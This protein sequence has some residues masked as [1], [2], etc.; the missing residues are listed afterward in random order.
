MKKW[1]SAIL[2]SVLLLAL[3]CQTGLAV[4]WANG[5]T[6]EM[7]TA[8]YWYNKC[9]TPNKVLL[10]L[11]EIRQLNEKI[12][13]N[14]PLDFVVDLTAAPLTYDGKQLIQELKDFEITATY[15]ID[16]QAVEDRFYE[17]A[18]ANIDNSQYYGVQNIRYAFVVKNTHLKWFPCEE[19]LSDAA[20][21]LEFDQT[22]FTTVYVGEPL[23]VKTASKDGKWYYVDATNYSGFVA[24]A[25]VALCTSRE[26]WLAYLTARR[27][28]DVLVVTGSSIQLEQTM[29]TTALSGL[30]LYMG[31]VLP[32]TPAAG[33]AASIDHRTPYGNYVV[34]V[35]IR[36]SD[37]SCQI[38]P[39]LIP[40]SRDVHLGYVPYTTANY[41]TQLFKELGNR[42]GWGGMLGA[43]D[44]SQYV[45][46]V[47]RCFGFVLARNGNWQ[48]AMP[49]TR[50]DLSGYESGEKAKVIA[51]LPS[52]ALLRFPGHIMFYLGSENG[53][54]YVISALG[55]FIPEGETAI[56]RVRTVTVNSLDVLRANGKTWLENMTAAILLQRPTFTDIAGLPQQEAIEA[57]AL[58]GI[59]IG[60]GG[61]FY[62]A[63]PLTRQELAV[64]VT[65]MLMLTQDA[66][67]AQTAFADVNG[68]GAGYIG[69]MLNAGILMGVRQ[70]RFAPNGTLTVEQGNLVLQRIW[71]KLDKEGEA[72]QCAPSSSPI[73]RAQFAGMLSKI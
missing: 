38:K 25:D 44:C 39:A 24:A 14:S 53:K 15:Y 51:S 43:L 64:L 16:G 23:V 1:M 70:D 62:P 56:R 10:S 34:D 32:L 72:P 69:A 58:R 73:T 49:V 17:A 48:E 26:Q 46:T 42:Y 9:D 59:V 13:E 65:R 66:K 12:V 47:G 7:N 52:G 60:C 36:L 57:L 18:R 28:D 55:N 21:D 31:T 37:G 8:A 61:Y 40:V 11:A 30:E 20:E 3:F 6:A 54:Q 33:I 19:Y 2:F 68:Y 45:D 50:I 5:V 35:P 67:A 27:G 22:Q 29:Y 63:Q 71:K 4:S 41:L